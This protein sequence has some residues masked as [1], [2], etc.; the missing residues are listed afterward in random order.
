M[1][2]ESAIA[3]PQIQAYQETNYHVDSAPPFV[4]KVG[5]FSEPLVQLYSLNRRDSAAYLTA[6]NPYSAHQDPSDNE[7]RQTALAQ[8]LNGRSLKF[9]PGV[10]RDRLEKCPGKASFLVLG[11][12]LEGAK[13]MAR[14][15]EQDA[16]LWRSPDS[17]LQLILLR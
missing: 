17:V 3:Q 16:L 9:I 14:K 6:C 5:V 15:Y 7:A 4:L 13:A 8:E 11:L 12:S 10:G 1:S 2:S